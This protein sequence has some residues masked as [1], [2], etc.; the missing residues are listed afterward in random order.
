MKLTVNKLDRIIK[1]EV[2][3]ATQAF[4]NLKAGVH[5]SKK[6]EVEKW[7]KKLTSRQYY[8]FMKAVEVSCKKMTSK[9]H[10][11]K[12]RR[13][14]PKN[15]QRFNDAVRSGKAGKMDEIDPDFINGLYRFIK[16]KGR[17]SAGFSTAMHGLLDYLS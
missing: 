5:A 6:V 9:T 15:I 11:G 13:K 8:S 16:A 17:D 4:R 1:E 2:E 10:S 14:C 7:L 12:T 3:E